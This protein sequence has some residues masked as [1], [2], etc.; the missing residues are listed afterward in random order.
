LKL[1]ATNTQGYQSI[2]AFEDALLTSLIPSKVP[3]KPTI[4]SVVRDQSNHTALVTFEEN[5]DP[6]A[7]KATFLVVKKT[8]NNG[9]ADTTE[10][11]EITWDSDGNVILGDIVA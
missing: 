3:G 5:R 7:S 6:D 2:D 11:Y 1:W 4:D 9:A 8:Y 10:T